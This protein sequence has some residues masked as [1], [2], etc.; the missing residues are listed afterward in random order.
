[1]KELTDLFASKEDLPL[2][3]GQLPEDPKGLG[4]EGDRLA[5]PGTELLRPELEHVLR[6]GASHKPDRVLQFRREDLEVIERELRVP[7]D[8][9][10]L[11]WLHFRAEDRG[12]G[13]LAELLPRGRR[14]T[15]SAELAVFHVD[16]G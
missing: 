14:C 2:T 8:A 10:R 9:D 6:G 3:S 12:E 1:M 7:D 5:P 16:G 15:S 4:R 13:S 11:P